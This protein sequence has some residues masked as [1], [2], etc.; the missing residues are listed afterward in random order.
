VNDL[1]KVLIERLEHYFLTYKL[2]PGESPKADI[3]RVY[4]LKHAIKVVNAS[5]EDY[6]SSFSKYL[7]APT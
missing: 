6:K 3:R 5:I 7:D 1:P 4:G 2:V